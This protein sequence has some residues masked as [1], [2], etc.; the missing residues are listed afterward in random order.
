M[1]CMRVSWKSLVDLERSCPVKAKFLSFIFL[2]VRVGN[3]LFFS[4]SFKFIKLILKLTGNGLVMRSDNTVAISPKR[5][6]VVILN[7]LIHHL[8]QWEVGTSDCPCP[9]ASTAATVLWKWLPWCQGPI[10][11]IIGHCISSKIPFLHMHSYGVL[12]LIIR[13]TWICVC[14]CFFSIWE[15]TLSEI[16]KH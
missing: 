13:L 12:C 9:V 2:C 15:T 1:W 14:S 6:Q 11:L 16:S 5:V 10:M 4:F 7:T 3:N 8:T